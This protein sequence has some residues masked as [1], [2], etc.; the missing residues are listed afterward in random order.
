MKICKC[1]FEIS[2]I[3]ILSLISTGLSF[4]NAFAIISLIFIPII[5]AIKNNSDVDHRLY[6]SKL[7]KNLLKEL[8]NYKT[9][10]YG[11]LDE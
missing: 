3:V 1:S 7:K 6:E 11:E 2:K 10:T 8:L 5:D 4:I 9:Q